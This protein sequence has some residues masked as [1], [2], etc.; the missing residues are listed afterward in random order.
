MSRHSVEFRLM[1]PSLDVCSQTLCSM[2]NNKPVRWVPPQAETDPQAPACLL[3]ADQTE[4][5]QIPACGG[6][7]WFWRFLS[8]CS[9][10]LVPTERL[11]VSVTNIQQ[12]RPGAVSTRTR[13]VKSKHI[14]YSA[15]GMVKVLEDGSSDGSWAGEGRRSSLPELWRQTHKERFQMLPTPAVIMGWMG[16]ALP[17]RQLDLQWCRRWSRWSPRLC[18]E[19]PWPLK[20]LAIKTNVWNNSNRATRT[21][22]AITLT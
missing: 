1:K 17:W 10:L 8:Q 9:A 5:G 19:I 12:H 11:E 13:Q 21:S 16:R 4:P 2:F 20:R 6:S 14:Y 22:T 7:V 3:V 15:K 18:T